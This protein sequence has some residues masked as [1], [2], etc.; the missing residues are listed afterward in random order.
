MDCREVVLDTDPVYAFVLDAI[1]PSL[2]QEGPCDL[3]QLLMCIFVLDE[4]L[5]IIL[6][7]S[8]DPFREEASEC[9]RLE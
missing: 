2:A 7:L 6:V 5:A 1:D 3:S 8:I 9:Q 4:A